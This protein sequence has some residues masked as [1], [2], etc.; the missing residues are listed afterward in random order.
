M[1]MTGRH[2]S[3]QNDQSVKHTAFYEGNLKIRCLLI[4]LKIHTL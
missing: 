3:T 2:Q 1:H 4:Y